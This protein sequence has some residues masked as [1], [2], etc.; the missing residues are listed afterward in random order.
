MFSQLTPLARGKV[1][2]K[3]FASL[4]SSIGRTQSVPRSCC[5]GDGSSCPVS[6]PPVSPLSDPWS[7]EPPE[8]DPPVPGLVGVGRLNVGEGLVSVIVG[9]VMLGVGRSMVIV[10][11]LIVGV[12]RSSV[13]LGLLNDDLPAR[14]DSFSSS[15]LLLPG[16]GNLLVDSSSSSSWVPGRGNLLSVVLLSDVIDITAE[17]GNWLV[18]SSAAAS[19]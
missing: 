15:V 16:R 19:S 3:A 4:D 1:P 12:G 6:P 7:E 18:D 8:S 10:G 2:F 9:R 17:R 13:K 5:K 14:L 11:L